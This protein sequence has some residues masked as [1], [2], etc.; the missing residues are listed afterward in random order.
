MLILKESIAKLGVLVPITVY[1]ETKSAT[2]PQEDTFMLL[3]GERRWVC[4]KDLKL[5]TIPAIIVE[6]P[7]DEQNILTMFHIH[8]LRVGWQLMPTALKLQVLMKKL[9]VRNERKLA[10]LTKLSV[11]Q[12]RRCKILLTY[13]KKFQNM[14][15]GPPDIRLKPDF[16]I[17]LQRIRLPALE[18][19]FPPWIRR[20]DA[21]CVS[22]ILKKYLDGDIKAVT[23]FRILT[24]IYRG[25]V[26][27]G[28][29]KR[30]YG[31][32]EKFLKDPKFSIDDF[33]VPGATFEKE[34]KEV[35]RSVKRLWKQI[36]GLDPEV[37][38]ANPEVVRALK[39]LREMI[40]FK[41][42]KALLV[43]PEYAQQDRSYLRQLPKTS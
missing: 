42:E 14:L 17:E 7:S 21:E 43:G 2:N 12:V 16:F 30:F 23:D 31:E 37:I 28:K 4:A 32:L 13:Q 20:G 38:S 5:P 6:Q 3:D 10:E 1:P 29:I 27:V 8:N 40:E 9:R 35:L 25:S 41:L 22:I 34:Y 24:E 18:K 39:T 26:R 11:S 19:R 33:D 36:R 15:L